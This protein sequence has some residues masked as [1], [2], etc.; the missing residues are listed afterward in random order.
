MTFDA[1][2]GAISGTTSA[3]FAQKSFTV[4]A[5]D[6]ASPAQTASFTVAISVTPAV[7]V[8]TVSSDGDVVEGSDAVFTVSASPAVSGSVT[9]SYSV[10]RTGNLVDSSEVATVSVAFSGSSAK[11][12]IPTVADDVVEI[13]GWVRVSLGARTGYTVGSAGTA[14]V[15]ISDDDPLLTVAAA[16]DVTEGTAASFTITASGRPWLGAVTVNYTL[17]ATG[18]FVAAGRLGS[19]S[20]TLG[21]AQTSAT[22]SVPTVQDSAVEADGSVT[23]TLDAAAANDYSVGTPG[24]AT[25]NVSDDDGQPQLSVTAGSD[26]TEGTA[27]GF[28]INA[29][30]SASS[31][32]TVHYTV[33]QSGSYVSSGDRGSQTV[34]LSGGSA[35][36]SVP[37]QA[38]S[39]DEAD[40]SVTVTLNAGSG[41]RVSNTSNAATVNVSDD[42][43][44]ELSVAAGGDVT[45]GT[46]AGFTISASP[47]ASSEVTVN[48]TVTQS[49]SYV[50]SGD[51][52]SQTV[53][54]SGGSATVSVP[55][56]ADSADEADGSVT[57]TLNTGSGYSVSNT[58]SAATVNVSDD[59]V[60]ELSVTAGAAVTE[61][62]AASFTIN[63]SPSAASQITVRYTVTQS[64]S[65][66]S[67]SDRGSQTVTLTGASA[68]VSVPTQAD[69]TD[70]PDGSVTVTLN[71]GSGYSV[72]NTSSAATVNVSDDDDPPATV[73]TVT[74]GAAV[75]EG[76]AASFTV[77]AAPPTAA[78]TTFGYAV[79]QQGDFAAP[80]AT[81]FKTATITGATATVAVATTDDGAGEA[82]GWI[83]VTLRTGNDYSVGTSGVASV[84]V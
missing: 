51:R 62:T 42:D 66:V 57:V 40:G 26:V 19:K 18:S 36:V 8:L 60:P 48:Y 69:S 25:V 33:T 27:A 32:V 37:T 29:S 44:P 58:S 76:A 4:T 13:D 39:A 55:T 52:G 30:P 59:D 45:E 38:D 79:T 22:V 12:T 14:T 16:G 7:P 71:T 65:Y 75:T 2:T 82:A 63:A 41:Y 34:A 80:G 28:T 50:S 73:L 11:I 53:A 5:T 3:V 35:T 21:T 15:N 47:S 20:L 46:A 23:L 78:A 67:S 74:G 17:A 56:Q 70:E 77:T 61:G 72:S 49:G 64:G 6:S 84:P 43:V 31:E 9:V 10:S 1:S 81:G 54:L 83:K 24:S 68:A